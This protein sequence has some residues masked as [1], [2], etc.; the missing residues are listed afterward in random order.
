MA[1]IYGASGIFGKA[2]STI[3]YHLLSPETLT[4]RGLQ[5]LDL[6]GRENFAPPYIYRWVM[7]PSVGSHLM[8][9]YNASAIAHPRA[10][11]VP[12]IF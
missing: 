10:A 9:Y 11:S 6:T 4:Q 12:I 3:L 2:F 1:Y 8:A 7:Y 5:A